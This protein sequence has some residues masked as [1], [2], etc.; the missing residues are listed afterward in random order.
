M[1]TLIE[2]YDERPVENV[3]G[4]EV[5]RPE[6]TVFLCPAEVAQDK[7]TQR[8]IREFFRHRGIKTETVFIEC[9]QYNA[10]KVKKQLR[11]ITEEYPDCVL[12]ITGGT[13]A[14][15]FAG[16][17]LCTEAE[18]PVFTY[19][20]RRNRFYNILNA[21]FAEALEC[22]VQY[23]VED[24]FQMAGGAL[25]MGRMDNTVLKKYEGKIEGFFALYLRHRGVWPRVTTYMQRASRTENDASV[26]LTV[27]APYTVKGEFGSR[28]SAPEQVLHELEELGF[29]HELKTELGRKVSFRFEDA[30][31]RAWLRDTGS[32]LELYVY[33]AC[34]DS[35]LFQ[36]V[37]MSAVVD[38]EAGSIRDGVT[39]EIDVIATRGIVPVFISCKTCAVST[40]ALNELAI[41][42][43]RFGGNIARAMIVTSQRCRNVTRHRAAE[44]AI[45]V[46]DIDDLT[47]GRIAALLET[48][49]RRED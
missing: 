21:P 22:T 18:M 48:I 2:L 35:G 4:T 9:S 32:V 40:E 6:R 43:D 47:D 8:I 38:W 14:A 42:R 11:R 26:S 46:I 39:N 23:S 28:I 13:D 12:D 30:Q 36:D 10:G 24:C 41:L 17:M 25:R 19:S 7:R 3:L 5:F 44:L 31:I 16:G 34:L 20:R 29:L 1:K 33:K 15:L 37:R 49:M 45:D 27:E